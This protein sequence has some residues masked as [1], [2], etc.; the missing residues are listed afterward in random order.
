MHVNVCYYIPWLVQ[1][2]SLKRGVVDSTEVGVDTWLSWPELP[3]SLP[4]SCDEVLCTIT[5]SAEWT[6]ELSLRWEIIDGCV[7]NLE[8]ALL[9][10][11]HFAAIAISRISSTTMKMVHSMDATMIRI[12]STCVGDKA[13]VSVMYNPH[14]IK[15]MWYTPMA[16]GY[17]YLPTSPLPLPLSTHTSL[18]RENMACQWPS[19]H[20]IYLY[21]QAW[22]ALPTIAMTPY[23]FTNFP[24]LDYYLIHCTG[25]N[26]S[27]G[28]GWTNNHQ[29]KGSVGR[30]NDDTLMWLYS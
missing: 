26:V 24:I 22:S 20:H 8:E 5:S 3:S 28:M 10:S 29:A 13:R 17:Y 6:A 19:S 4:D 7:L 2:G 14:R 1:E 21:R 18:N 27:W 30:V 25:G 9:N 11:R 23:Q 12:Q 15:W 16:S